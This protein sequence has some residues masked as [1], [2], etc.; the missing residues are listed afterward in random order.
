MVRAWY[1]VM[2]PTYEYVPGSGWI[3]QQ[4]IE[5]TMAC[6]TRVRLEFR[7]PNPGERAE[8]N[9]PGV[10]NGSEWISYFERTK[11]SYITMHGTVNPDYEWVTVVSV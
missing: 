10:W 11:L 2:E 9:E 8:F 6:G 4:I 5:I 1:R 3:P 7:K